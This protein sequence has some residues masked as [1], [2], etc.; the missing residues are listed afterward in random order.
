MKGKTVSAPAFT[1]D[2]IHI[3]SE[4]PK[5]SAD[6]YVEMFGATIAADTVARPPHKSLSISAE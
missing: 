5:A 6:W 2:H 3:I 1:F 4:N